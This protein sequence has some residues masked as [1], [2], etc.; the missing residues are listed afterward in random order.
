[1]QLYNAKINVK[2]VPPL[3]MQ[4]QIQCLKAFT[5]SD[6]CYEA[7]FHSMS[8]GLKEMFKIERYLLVLL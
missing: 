4:M 1:M 5:A 7:L 6:C 3:Q 2:A 8:L